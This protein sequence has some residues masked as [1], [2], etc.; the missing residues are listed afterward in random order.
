VAAPGVEVGW[1]GKGGRRRDRSAAARH[2]RG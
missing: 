2:N 1:V